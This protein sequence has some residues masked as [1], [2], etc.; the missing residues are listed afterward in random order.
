[1]ETPKEPQSRA[2]LESTRPL[3]TATQPQPQAHL[4]DDHFY[5]PRSRDF[6]DTASN[7]PSVTSTLPV[8]AMPKRYGAFKSEHA[9]LVALQEFAEEKKY[10]EPSKDMRVE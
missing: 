1:M 10:M 5:S 2:S 8:Q 3:L 4:N 7:A 6:G 9:Y